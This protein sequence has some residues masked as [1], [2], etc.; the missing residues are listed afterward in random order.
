MD[1]TETNRL[2][3]VLRTLRAAPAS[4]PFRAPVD[5]KRLNLDDYPLV[6]RQPM[7]L[8]TV[9][10]K[11]K[12]RIYKSVV[13]FWHD[14]D[15][16]WTNCRTFNAEEAEAYELANEMEQLASTLRGDETSPLPSRPAPPPPPSEV[17]VF[18]ERLN[19]LDPALTPSVLQYITR[20][21]PSCITHEEDKVDIDV[22]ALFAEHPI[23]FRRAHGLVKLLLV[24][25]LQ[26]T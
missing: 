22:G 16:I 21:A 4:W 1:P 7:D 5:W 17:L 14:I 15:L 23:A 12:S 2:T 20:E 11:L 10:N 8:K 3:R 24:S 25:S 13:E 6:I 26:T 19:L 18:C 9:S